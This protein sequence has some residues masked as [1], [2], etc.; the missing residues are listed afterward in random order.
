MSKKRSWSIFLIIPILFFSAL[1]G[2]CLVTVCQHVFYG[3]AQVP[4][5]VEV[6]LD[7]DVPFFTDPSGEVHSVLKKG[8]KVN[9]TA[10]HTKD[11]NI[12]LLAET[13]DGRRGVI[14]TYPLPVEPI[15]GFDPH[16]GTYKMSAWEFREKCIGKTF[17]DFDGKYRRTVFVP[18]N[19]RTADSVDITMPFALRMSSDWKV[20]Q[21]VVTY[22]KGIAKEVRYVRLVGR[23][24]LP[25][26]ILPGTDWLIEIPFVQELISSP[27]YMKD[28]PLHSSKW[29]YY[30]SFP[31]KWLGDLM[32]LFVIGMIP[33]LLLAF[34]VTYTPIFRLLNNTIMRILMIG[35][36]VVGPY[37]WMLTIMMEGY[38]WGIAWF[39]P[40]CSMILGI[41]LTLYLIKRRCPKCR[42]IAVIRIDSNYKG[43]E[44]K[45]F[46][47][48]EKKYFVH[49][50]KEMGVKR[51]TEYRVKYTSSGTR[52]DDKSD[53][54][55]QW[56]EKV[57]VIR[58]SGGVYYDTYDMKYRED[59]YRNKYRCKK[60]GHIFEK[61]E[62]ELTF[63]SKTFT[64]RK[65]VVNYTDHVF[66]DRS[67]R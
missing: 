19:P 28:E 61:D 6:T 67:R 14:Q 39:F 12:T 4:E 65:T 8:T 44:I 36:S 56:D 48:T 27:Q 5:F 9:I 60:C 33:I 50:E 52:T 38:W 3:G 51:H 45:E 55:R 10:Y 22:K 46:E 54:F 47:R 31:I 37:L 20:Y 58:E 66:E 41:L 11:R 2:L 29:M 32:Y 7:K 34:L 18:K 64:G 24:S 25:L 16:K 42:R 53:V 35:V 62:Q 15:Y 57:P 17:S 63:L 59:K 1:I 40:L 49:Q 30:L 13:K 21:P 43:S 26:R 23:N